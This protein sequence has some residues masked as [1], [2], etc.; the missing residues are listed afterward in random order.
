MKNREI[1]TFSREFVIAEM[2]NIPTI[3]SRSVHLTTQPNYIVTTNF[4]VI[5]EKPRSDFSQSLKR[6]AKNL[7]LVQSSPTLQVPSPLP[8]NYILEKKFGAFDLYKKLP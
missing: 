1:G 3:R 5:E 6:L 2:W 7:N 8:T 4:S